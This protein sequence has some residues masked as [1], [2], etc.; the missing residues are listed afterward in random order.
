MFLYFHVYLC[1]YENYFIIVEYIFIYKI[2]LICAKFVQDPASKEAIL[3]T[4]A[5][6]ADSLDRNRD[7]YSENLTC[8]GQLL[9]VILSQIQNNTVPDP[10]LLRVAASIVYPFCSSL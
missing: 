8:H 3:T 5:N 7:S 10:L 9:S 1:I 6:I 4:M 2:L